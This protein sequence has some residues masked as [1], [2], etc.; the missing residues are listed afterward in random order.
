[1]VALFNVRILVHA[2]ICSAWATMTLDNICLYLYIFTE[3]SALL[4]RSCISFWHAV[5]LPC[6]NNHFGFC[7]RA[8]GKNIVESNFTFK[9]HCILLA[10]AYYVTYFD[11][12]FW[13]SDYIF[14]FMF[15]QHSALKASMK[16]IKRYP[17]L[18]G[19]RLLKEQLKIKA[20]LISFI[21]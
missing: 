19:G 15:L 12:Y 20:L 18:A 3:C 11:S 4:S 21:V 13:Q 1:M 8:S 17:M 16:S 5:L 9:I 6:T 2:H 7:K 10:W 14:H